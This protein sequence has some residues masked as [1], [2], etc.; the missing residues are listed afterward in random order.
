MMGSSMSVGSF[1]RI[2]E[3]FSRTSWTAMSMSRSRT[4]STVTTETPSV[5]V[6][7]MVLTPLIVLMASS[8]LSVTSMSMI[9]GLAPL[10]RVVTLT[11]GKSTFGYR[12]TP[13]EG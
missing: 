4:N 10:S 13:M 7:A 5:L 11:M 12:S 6:E 1:A 8:I 9:S 3:T 2:V